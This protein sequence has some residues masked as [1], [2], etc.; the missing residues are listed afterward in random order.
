MADMSWDSVLRNRES[1]PDDMTVEM[2]GTP[3]ALGD[4]RNEVIPKQDMT[5]LTQGWSA[6]EQ[7]NRAQIETLQQQLAQALTAANRQDAGA[8][9]YETSSAPPGH[10][11]PL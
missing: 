9:A 4:L 11:A 3:I 5:R 8:N 10:G 7:S 1:F 2:N 6:R